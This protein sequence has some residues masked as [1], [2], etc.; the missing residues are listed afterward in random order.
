V[1]ITKFLIFFTSMLISLQSIVAMHQEQ[2]AKPRKEI[3]RTIKASQPISFPKLFSV[4]Y[5]APLSATAFG[6]TLGAGSALAPQFLHSDNLLTTS[7]NSIVKKIIIAIPWLSLVFGLGTHE[8]AL[9][10]I[11]KTKKN[12][13]DKEIIGLKLLSAAFLVTGSYI[14]GRKLMLAGLEKMDLSP[15][16]TIMSM[17]NS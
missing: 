4:N 1:R 15:L 16:V 12:K 13:F 14:L 11:T 7:N 3:K 10:K 2:P 8:I 17:Y 6:F 9:E 5:A